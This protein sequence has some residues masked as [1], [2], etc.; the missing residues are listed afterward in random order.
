MLNIK[1]L[2]T[3]VAAAALVSAIGL[4]YAQ[5]SPNPP[6]ASDTAPATPTVLPGEAAGTAAPGTTPMPGSTPSTSAN[7]ALNGN[8]T[9]PAPKA[10]RN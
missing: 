5:T 1:S 8:V 4:A 9:E 2:S 10:D 6:A 7:D 3:A